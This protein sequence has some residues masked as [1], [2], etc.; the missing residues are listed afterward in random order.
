MHVVNKTGNKFVAKLQEYAKDGEMFD[1]QPM[2][3][4]CTLDIVCGELENALKL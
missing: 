3:K 2:V 4:K 1:I